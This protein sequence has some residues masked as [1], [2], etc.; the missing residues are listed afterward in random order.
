ME[1]LLSDNKEQFINL[2]EYEIV[3]ISGVENNFAS[4]ESIKLHIESLENQGNMVIGPFATRQETEN[5]LKYLNTRFARFMVSL[6]QYTQNTKSDSYLL[7]PLQDFT[8]GSDIDWSKSIPEIDQQLY[9]KYNLSSD[10][11][12]FIEKMIKPME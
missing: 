5:A 10:E 2:N 9:A 3:N 12:T 11:T 4:T 7:V 8:S 1:K 6:V